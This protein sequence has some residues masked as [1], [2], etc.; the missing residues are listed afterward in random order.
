MNNVKEQ[1]GKGK[2]NVI[3]KCVDESEQIDVPVASI[4]FQTPLSL[5]N[6]VKKDT[7]YH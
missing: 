5:L 6:E 3:W 7:S 4:N 2:R 1:L